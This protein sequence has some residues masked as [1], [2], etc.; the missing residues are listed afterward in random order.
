MACYQGTDP[1]ERRNKSLLRLLRLWTVPNGHE[2]GSGGSF[3][4]ARKKGRV[5]AATRS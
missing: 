4:D 5:G 3:S 2:G 1:R